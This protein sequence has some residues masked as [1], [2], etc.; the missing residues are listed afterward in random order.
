MSQLSRRALLMRGLQYGSSVATGALLPAFLPDDV[1]ANRRTRVMLALWDVPATERPSRPDWHELAAVAL[2]A[3]RDGGAQYADVLYCA[4][5]T[6]DWIFFLGTDYPIPR[7]GWKIGVGVR[8]L[9]HGYWGFAGQSDVPATDGMAWLGREAAAQ[10]RT[11]AAGGKPRTVDLASTTPSVGQWTM[12]GIDPFT[13]S[14]AEKVD[15][16]SALNDFIGRRRYAANAMSVPR[17]RRDERIFASTDG[18]FTSQVTFRSSV[19]LTVGAGADWRTRQLGRR[20]TDELLPA[21]AGWEYVRATTLR[22]RADDLLDYA[23]RM[24]RPKPVTPGRYDIVFDAQAAARMMDGSIGAAT[25]LDR[26]MGYLANTLGTSYLR[27]P[28]AMLGTFA[29]GSPH[30]TVTM[31]RSMPGGASTVRWDDEGIAPRDVTLV[32]NGILEDYQTTRESASWLAPY[33]ERRGVP[34]HSNGCAGVYDAATPVSQC[35]PN[36]AIAPGPESLTMTDLIKEVK[37]GL[38]VFGGTG[39]MDQQQLN[40]TGRG[41]SDVMFEITNGRL[42]S[43]IEGAEYV[44]RSPEF[45]KNLV[46]VGGPSSVRPIGIERAREDPTTSAAYTVAAVPIAVRNVVVTDAMGAS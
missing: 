44:Y 29:I 36:L 4:T 3:A 12:P 25:E 13:V 30:L 24:R 17:F 5:Q 46:A 27:D 2:S 45:W 23:F 20:T 9:V 6:E 8:A 31:N 15:Y 11:A 1:F 41:D 38:A 18:A 32:R 40:G 42:G 7:L 26:A 10:G 16:F 28:L 39:L 34:I 43:A 22:E 21:G 14:F 33:Y 35:P 37:Q 19:A